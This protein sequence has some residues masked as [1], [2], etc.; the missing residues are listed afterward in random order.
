MD[1]YKSHELQFLLVY[2]LHSLFS[3]VVSHYYKLGTTNISCP[4]TLETS[5]IRLEEAQSL[6]TKRTFQQFQSTLTFYEKSIQQQTCTECSHRHC[7]LDL[8]PVVTIYTYKQT[9]QIGLQDLN[10]QDI[11]GDILS[12]KRL[13]FMYIFDWISIKLM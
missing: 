3:F 1:C 7:L 11:L 8:L 6:N 12:T 9:K 4:F 10:S 5:T 13:V 2:N